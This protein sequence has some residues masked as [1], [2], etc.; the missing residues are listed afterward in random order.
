MSLKE[1]I[2]PTVEE[3]KATSTKKVT[4]KASSKTTAKAPVKK[5]VAKS[6]P[7]SAAKSTTKKATPKST[8]TATTTAT[9]KS[10]PKAVTA[11]PND[12]ETPKVEAG[13]VA[14][15]EAT[16]TKVL[17][18][19][20]TKADAKTEVIAEPKASTEVKTTTVKKPSTK[21]LAT[22]K[23]V[24]SLES[25]VAST[26]LQSTT[27]QKLTAKE[28]DN[29]L[30]EKLAKA[31]AGKPVPET[32]AP[33]ETNPAP[34]TEAQGESSGLPPLTTVRPKPA[35]TVKAPKK[36][37]AKKPAPKKATTKKTTTAS[38]TT[39]ATTTKTAAQYSTPAK[40]KAAGKVTPKKAEPKKAE[41][42]KV[43]V[44]SELT[45]DDPG[46]L[47]VLINEAPSGIDAAL[48][49]ANTPPADVD[50]SVLDTTVAKS[51]KKLDQ[52]VKPED[53]P[54]VGNT[55]AFLAD[56][57]NL[58]IDDDEEATL[59]D[60]QAKAHM[61]HDET[62][63]T[64]S[65][66]NRLPVTEVLNTEDDDPPYAAESLDNDNDD[67]LVEERRYHK[68]VT[69]T[70]RRAPV[71][72]QVK[73]PEPVLPTT[74]D[75]EEERIARQAVAKATL[76]RRQASRQVQRD[77]LEARLS[78]RGLKAMCRETGIPEETIDALE[79]HQLIQKRQGVSQAKANVA[80]VASD[81]RHNVDPLWRNDAE[82]ACQEHLE[83]TTA[84]RPPVYPFDASHGE[85][86]DQVS[87]QGDPNT[88][89]PRVAAAAQYAEAMVDWENKVIAEAKNDRL[90]SPDR[91]KEPGKRIPVVTP[92][93]ETLGGF[94]GARDMRPW[95]MVSG[96]KAQTMPLTLVEKLDHFRFKANQWLARWK[97]LDALLRTSL[98]ALGCAVV[99]VGTSISTSY[100][101][102]PELTWRNTPVTVTALVADDEIRDLMLLV[103]LLENQKV[104]IGRTYPTVNRAYLPTSVLDRLANDTPEM[105][106]ALALDDALLR[107]AITEVSN[108]VGAP[109]ISKK[110]VLATPE[111]TYNAVGRTLDVTDDV[112][113][114]LGLTGVS[115]AA[116]KAALNGLM[117]P[118][119]KPVTEKL[120]SDRLSGVIPL[121]QLNTQNKN[122]HAN[123][124]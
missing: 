33:T 75:L 84:T 121:G 124:D 1:E 37:A 30:D 65:V 116:A 54:T 3:T 15:N 7:K 86:S 48:E 104:D 120:E 96:Q 66:A 117:S 69:L 78:K 97:A 19:A 28:M 16:E 49:K 58:P 44:A 89:D 99:A 92:A 22:K 46:L 6:T 39:K 111:S 18:T 8:T 93:N 68:T 51:L 25:N 20:E 52:P 76:D 11:K 118:N 98:V 31:H 123:H 105:R 60:R 50:A 14:S 115:A 90:H 109:V 102:V 62:S 2:K 82:R 119:G 41:P 67:E 59:N 110:L 56:D 85:V 103:S 57:G 70:G 113:E 38:A 27:G 80:Q 40:A 4:S 21:K 34:W 91:N 42:K 32:D 55:L 95:V 23:P 45:N 47:G 94:P 61:R 83:R 43:E 87:Y 101:L 17:T 79:T 64:Q 77:E 63:S 71:K 26:R 36:T 73:D 13:L 106:R 72:G 29:K 108:R 24:A 12:A 35:V 74:V 122:K 53:V 114:L 100:W 10:T 88:I 9:T 112:I 107:A 81:P 5:P